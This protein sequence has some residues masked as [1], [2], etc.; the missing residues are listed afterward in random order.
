MDEYIYKR[1]ADVYVHLDSQDILCVDCACCLVDDDRIECKKNP[2][3]YKGVRL[4]QP[5]KRKEGCKKFKWHWYGKM[6]VAQH[7]RNMALEKDNNKMFEMELKH[8]D[9]LD[10][11]R[12]NSIFYRCRRNW[13]KSNRVISIRI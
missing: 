4:A 12:S 11:V 13:T 1:L 5:P 6:I 7:I 2:A 9:R 8:Q 10:Q 3:S